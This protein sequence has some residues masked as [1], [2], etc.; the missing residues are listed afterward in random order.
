MLQK[1]LG[2]KK[3]GK[4]GNARAAAR[5]RDRMFGLLEQSYAM[6]APKS[7]APMWQG[8]LG[9]VIELLKKAPHERTEADLEA[10]TKYL[11]TECS[12]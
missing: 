12:Q 6:A 4:P 2:I 10:V 8:K 7:L 11:V 9:G 5:K 1:V 3:G